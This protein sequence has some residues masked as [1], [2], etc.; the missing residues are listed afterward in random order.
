MANIIINNKLYD[1]THYLDDHPG[2]IDII[3][4]LENTDATHDFFEVGH[5]EKAH[6]LLQKYY[7]KDMPKKEAYLIKETHIQKSTYKCLTR[8]NTC[9]N[10]CMFFLITF[11]NT[12]FN[13]HMNITKI[14]RDE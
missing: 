8:I 13:D 4:K 9:L 10:K 7:I 5:S 1:L 14:K 6:E 12:S 2:G 3:K 11:L